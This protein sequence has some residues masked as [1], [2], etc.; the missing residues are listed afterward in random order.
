MLDIYITFFSNMDLMILIALMDILWFLLK[1]FRSC[2]N[3][4]YMTIYNLFIILVLW[5]RFITWKENVFVTLFFFLNDILNI[6]SLYFQ[7]LTTMKI[8]QFEFDIISLKIYYVSIIYDIKK[9]HT[10]T[11]TVV[12]LSWL[13]QMIHHLSLLLNLD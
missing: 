5:I 7:A 6:I 4:Y 12:I 13:W 2:C 8:N 11:F 3:I 1:G 9:C 10:M